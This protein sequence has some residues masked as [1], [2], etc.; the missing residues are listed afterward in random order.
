LTS[1]ADLQAR[2]QNA[3]PRGVSNSLAI[4][5]E[6]AANAELWDVEGRRYID[7][8]SGISV[9]NTGHLHAKVKE[10]LAQQLEKIT[11]ACF[12]V[13]PYESYVALAEK[14]NEAAPGKTPKKTLFLTTG[15]EAVENAIKIARAATGRS[16]VIAFE[17]SFH[18][19]T[20]LAL[21]LTGKVRPYRQ[22]FGPF[23]P[24][25]HTLPYPYVYRCPQHSG[26][27]GSD[28]HEWREALERA[29]LTRIPAEQVAAIIVEP[30]QG[31][32]GFI[33]PP[34]HFLPELRDICTEHG[35]LLII[36]EVQSGFGRTGKLFAIEHS[37]VAPDLML[38]AKSLAG[39]LPLAAVV[40]RAEYLDAPLPGGLGGTYG[41]NPVACAAALAVLDVFAREGLADRGR[42][43]GEQAMARMREWRERYPL[44]G[45]VRGLGA[46]VAVELVT[47]RAQRTPAT[48]AA[49]R[50]LVE[51][52][53]RG[54]ILIKAGLYDNVIRLLM[55]LVTTDD[56]LA[57]GLDILEAALGVV[58]K[59]P[60][61]EL[62]AH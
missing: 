28:C 34:A 61:E 10:A 22:D 30:V 43:L 11:H 52:R 47:D 44:V 1:N 33:V 8:G 21:A 31:E 15:A 4:Y 56:E 18:G 14:L 19:R 39:G 20:N 32:G 60:A 58:S 7:F 53:E 12:Q 41:G 24:N 37:D 46:M 6:R 29:F 26:T 51:A 5:A 3:I 54:L 9:L 38:M 59:L 49:G 27:D 25:I 42:A 48:G 17:N 13:T 55:P 2:R 35:I 40:G 23:A 57:E 50:I 16:G 36:D 62:A 45:E